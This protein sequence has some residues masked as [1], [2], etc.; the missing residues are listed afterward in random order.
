MA[1]KS[2][3][4]SYFVISL[5]LE[6]I[7]GVRDKKSISDYGDAIEGVRHMMPTLL[8]V[9]R[10][11]EV[12]ATF[13]TVGFLFHA[14][15][16]DLLSTL[17]DNKP[18][19][20]DSNLSPYIDLERSIGE[21]EHVDLFHYGKS[22]IDQ[23]KNE[24]LHEIG[25]HTYSHYYCLEPGQQLRDFED[26]I[27]LAIKVAEDYKI[28]LTSIV[29]PRN[30]YAP[31]YLNVCKE[32]NIVCYRGNESSWVFEPSNSTGQT[33]IK[34]AVRL[35]DSYFNITGYHCYSK[36]Q[37]DDII[38]NIPS[39]RFLRPYDSK[40]ELFDWLKLRRIKKAMTYA[41]KNNLIYHLWWHPHNFG[42]DSKENI[43]MLEEI[44]KHYQ[45]LHK[46][47]DMQSYT[48]TGLVKKIKE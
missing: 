6:L 31:D 12:K 15:K 4:C 5:D 2:F 22:I 9:F 29:F 32:N 37:L 26:D 33:I 19:Y 3:D 1:E 41:A 42:R 40:L 10:Q 34:R 30:Q 36:K 39:S 14:R 13:A 45:F 44:L 25:T 11:Y 35:L 43:R 28:E 38:I 18:E 8:N 27:K 47:Y 16:G 24:A 17:P 48:M 46:K 21:G 20:E 23:I 7:W